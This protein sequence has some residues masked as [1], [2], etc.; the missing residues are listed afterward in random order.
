M[1]SLE[2]LALPKL[3]SRFVDL[4]NRNRKAVNE[5][6]HRTEN[7]TA[8]RMMEITRELQSR[9]EDGRA[10][11]IAMLDHEEETVRMLAA[12][13]VLDFAPERALPV[14]EALKTMNHR[15]SRGKPLSDLLHFNV[16]ASGVLWRWREER[17]L[18]NPD[19]TPLGLNIEEF[20]RRRDEEMADISAKLQEEE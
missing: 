2:K 10:A 5:R 13:R 17:G 4:A 7:R 12:A 9:G 8:W 18:N 15:D 3:V 19:E 11:L 20:N 14:L 16:F 1:T 6:K